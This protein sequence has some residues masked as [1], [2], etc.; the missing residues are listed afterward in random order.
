M[1]DSCYDLLF[2]QRVLNI[3]QYV[4]ILWFCYKRP[5]KVDSNYELDYN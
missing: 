2:L 4:L 3:T 5:L 1:E